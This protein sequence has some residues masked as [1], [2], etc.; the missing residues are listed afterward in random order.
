MELTEWMFSSKNQ[1]EFLH[2]ISIT[3]TTSCISATKITCRGFIKY[4]HSVFIKYTIIHVH[5]NQRKDTEENLWEGNRELREQLGWNGLHTPMWLTQKQFSCCQY[6]C[7]WSQPN[8]HTPLPK[9]KPKKKQKTIFKVWHRILLLVCH[10]F[11]AI[12]YFLNCIFSNFSVT[13]LFNTVHWINR[14]F[15]TMNLHFR[16]FFTM[17]LPSKLPLPSAVSTGCVLLSNFWLCS[18]NWTIKEN[19]PP[20]LVKFSP[21][22]SLTGFFF[23]FLKIPSWYCQIT[24]D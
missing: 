12:F 18:Q 3:L 17:N 22:C 21:I 15:F 14:Y 4:L 24:F 11:R 1:N 16:N 19:Q 7:L 2:N 20:L 10:S 23:K 9:K 13:Y 6:S 8:N 5:Q